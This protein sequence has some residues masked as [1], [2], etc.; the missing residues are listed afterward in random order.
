MTGLERLGLAV[1]AGELAF[2]VLAAVAFIVIYWSAPWER[3]PAGRH[4]MYVSIAW[5][6]EKVALLVMLLGLPVSLWVF[7]VG[8]AVADAVVLHRLWLLYLARRGSG[9]AVSG[10]D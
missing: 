4:L 10:E 5:G 9:V 3:S 6:G 8:Y 7:V 1:V 2:G